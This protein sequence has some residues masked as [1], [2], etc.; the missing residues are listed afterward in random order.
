MGEKPLPVES[1]SLWKLILIPTLLLLAWSLIPTF[2]P[3]YS[4]IAL[5]INIFLI[6]IGVVGFVLVGRGRRRI[7]QILFGNSFFLLIL[8]MGA[9]GWFV[10]V[11]NVGLW[12]LWTSVILAAYFLASV[13]RSSPLSF[14]FKEISDEWACSFLLDIICNH[15]SRQLE[16]SNDC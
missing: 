16:K 6:L 12:A 15:R 10:I 3:Q 2:Y 11:G 4:S 9:R 7:G 13:Y 8:A 14:D 5:A 1:W